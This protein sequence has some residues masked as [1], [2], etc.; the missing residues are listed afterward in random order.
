MFLFVIWSQDRVRELSSGCSF[1]GKR[2]MLIIGAAI[3]NLVHIISGVLKH[4]RSFNHDF[5]QAQQARQ[6]RRYLTLNFRAAK[7]R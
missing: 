5:H 6:G 1:R 7:T 4:N 2:N 3:R